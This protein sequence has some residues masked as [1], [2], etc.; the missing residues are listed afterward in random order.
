M[1]VPF[2]WRSGRA[3]EPLDPL[4]WSEADRAELD[5]LIVAMCDALE[6]HKEK[7][8]P[9]CRCETSRRIIEPVLEWRSWRILNSK[10]EKLRELR[11]GQQ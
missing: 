11:R 5:I 6:I 10:A 7:H 8:G 9:G 1:P 4:W 2:G 3:L